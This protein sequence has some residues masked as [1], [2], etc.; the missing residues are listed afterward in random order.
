MI[1]N[2]N[3][4]VTLNCIYEETITLAVSAGSNNILLPLHSDGEMP[5]R[6]LLT[7][8]AATLISFTLTPLE[9][10]LASLGEG[11]SYHRN[12]G[13]FCFEPLGNL[14]INT[15]ASGAGVIHLTP[16]SD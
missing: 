12:Q 14:W 15:W 2:G 1:N 7:T 3:N 8:E 13:W 5:R 6:I 9:D 11:V 4:I 16:L 10:S